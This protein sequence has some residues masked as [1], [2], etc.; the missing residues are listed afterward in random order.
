MCDIG[1]V[2][3]QGNVT[4]PL[5]GYKVFSQAT[6]EL[7]SFTIA[8]G[9]V[10][11]GE[12]TRYDE[13][14]P[15]PRNKGGCKHFKNGFH[16]FVSSADAISAADSWDS[17]SLPVQLKG[18]ITIANQDGTEIIVGEWIYVPTVQELENMDAKAA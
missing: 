15:F 5:Q 12:W 17:V 2:L 6:D 10:P 14:L 1:T 3:G 13:V 11:R 7:C 8:R 9:S 4:K 16:A 18:D